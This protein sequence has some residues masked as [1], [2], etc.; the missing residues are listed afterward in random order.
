MFPTGE[1]A[2]GR[3]NEEGESMGGVLLFIA[4]CLTPVGSVVRRAFDGWELAVGGADPGGPAMGEETAGVE[5]GLSE[6]GMLNPILLGELGFD[7]E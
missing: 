7:D 3:G 5:L 4:L 6:V 1:S 2:V